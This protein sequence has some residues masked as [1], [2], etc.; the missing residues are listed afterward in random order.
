MAREKATENSQGENRGEQGAP[1]PS[2]QRV[3]DSFIGCPAL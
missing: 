1:S 2:P 3:E